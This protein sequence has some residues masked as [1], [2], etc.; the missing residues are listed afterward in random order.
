[1]FCRFDPRFVDGQLLGYALYGVQGTVLQAW[2]ME[3][4]KA[5]R[6]QDLLDAVN[7]ARDEVVKA[8]SSEKADDELAGKL[9][10]SDHG[11]RLCTC[12][13]CGHHKGTP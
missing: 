10:V 5:T 8:I 7:E 2:C 12:A 4:R 6:K 1:V 11:S 3:T 9:A 13:A